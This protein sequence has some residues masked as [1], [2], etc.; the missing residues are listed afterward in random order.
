[1][2]SVARGRYWLFRRI[3][4]V[5]ACLIPGWLILVILEWGWRNLITS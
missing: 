5:I 4:T 1:M 2:V 3:D